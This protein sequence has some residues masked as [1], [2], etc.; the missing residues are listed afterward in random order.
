MNEAEDGHE[1][2]LKSSR[3]HFS[4]ETLIS[5]YLSYMLN[6]EFDTGLVT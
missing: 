3:A 2:S 6:S 5:V 1:I 4:P